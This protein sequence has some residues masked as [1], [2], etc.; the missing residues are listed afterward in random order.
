MERKIVY[1]SFD[2]DDMVHIENIRELAIK[3]GYIPVNPEQALG[4]YLSTRC[5]G[6]MKF[7]VMKDCLSLARMSNEFW[8]FINNDNEDYSLALLS[9]GV[10][11]EI[12]FWIK[13]GGSSIKIFSIPKMTNAFYNRSIYNGVVKHISETDLAAILS[14]EF[15]NEISEYLADV[16]PLLRP[17]VFIDIQ[18]D[19]F[20]YVDWARAYSFE[21]ALVPLV[22]QLTL[23]EM[24]Y[25]RY[26]LENRH[27]E[28]IRIVQRSVSKIWAIFKSKKNQADLVSKYGHI[29]SKVDFIPIQK[30]GIPKYT[31]PANWSITT[32]E[33]EENV[34][35]LKKK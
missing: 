34:D 9:E 29:L 32:K 24:V 7:E 33:Y 11:I 12:L 8:V 1:T 22:Q 25:S 20:K 27:L 14:K 30:L 3:N 5:H 23:P 6:D 28:D 16:L 13:I 35:I 26:G 4:Y 31:N 19:D 18:N 15:F 10:V 2:G 17:V 21:L